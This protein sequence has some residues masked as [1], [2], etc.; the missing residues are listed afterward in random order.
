MAVRAEYPPLLLA[1][2]LAVVSGTAVVEY[3]PRVPPVSPLHNADDGLLRHATRDDYVADLGRRRLGDGNNA[4]SNQLGAPSF[5]PR[6]LEL[7]DNKCLISIR[8]TC[9]AF[10]SLSNTVDF[11][12][13]AHGGPTATNGDHC[14]GRRGE[15][16]ALCG[17]SVWVTYRFVTQADMPPTELQLS[18]RD[19][20][21]A[22][23]QS[24]LALAKVPERKMGN[25]TALLR[26]PRIKESGGIPG[27][28][29]TGKAIQ[30]WGG[31]SYLSQLH[32][33]VRWVVEQHHLQYG[34][35]WFKGRAQ[36][37]IMAALG[38]KPHHRLLEMGCG[39]LRAGVHFIQYLEK[40]NYWGLE[41]DEM[42]LRAGIQYE[43]AVN[44][45]MTKWPHFLLDDRFNLDHLP[46]AEQ[47]SE[48]RSLFDFV[49]FFAVLKPTLRGLWEPALRNAHDRLAPKGRVVIIGDW[50][51][52][53]DG[54]QW[55][56]PRVGGLVCQKVRLL[57][58]GRSMWSSWGLAWV[59][60][61]EEE[62]RELQSYIK[63][64][65]VAQQIAG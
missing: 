41:K 7:Q 44:G 63:E 65:G 13:N 43:L 33:D 50:P 8:G 5:A 62:S 40:G 54:S 34:E 57:G 37:E 48:E 51:T 18:S 11:D 6:R 59:C 1:A 16:E 4:T 25:V 3:T 49:V 32:L 38:L 39:A 2:V 17:R 10:P 21:F 14:K 12:D 23:V 56:L 61:K 55:S 52:T 60:G 35:P 28:E 53:F 24:T 30:L 15:W 58:K 46:A 22:F 27:P 42:S 29:E 19:E 26:K 31:T 20:Y 36:L 64:T 9:P 45:L 47:S